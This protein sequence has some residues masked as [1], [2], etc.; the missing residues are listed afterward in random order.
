MKAVRKV[1]DEELEKVR[2]AHQAAIEALL[3]KLSS[4]AQ[5]GGGGS[6]RSGLGGGGQ[7]T[8]GEPQAGAL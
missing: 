8:L 2:A 1:H 6:L 7:L 3:A 5:L 4:L